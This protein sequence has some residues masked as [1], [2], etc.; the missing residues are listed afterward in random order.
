MTKQKKRLKI[1]LVI[2]LLAFVAVFSLSFLR[3]DNVVYATGNANEE[4]TPIYMPQKLCDY[5]YEYNCVCVVAD[6]PITPQTPT[7]NPQVPCVLCDEY[8]CDCHILFRPPPP[9][10]PP[11][12]LECDLIWFLCECTAYYPTY[13]PPCDVCECYAMPNKPC[14]I[15][16][17]YNCDN[18][19]ETIYPTGCIRCR[20]GNCTSGFACW[21]FGNWLLITIIGGSALLLLIVIVVVIIITKKRKASGDSLAGTQKQAQEA[22]NDAFGELNLADNF[23]QASIKDP[24]NT[25]KHTDAMIQLK[26]VDAAMKDAEKSIDNF[27]KEKKLLNPAPVQPQPL[28]PQTTSK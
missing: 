5:H 4:T 21:F 15:C 14:A 19:C 9:P 28:P 1:F 16:G 10:L 27:L 11:R 7:D 13:T 17:H 25:K 18:A 20:R 23:V 3:V 24:S 12:C 8:N 6:T 26:I 22:I 2:L